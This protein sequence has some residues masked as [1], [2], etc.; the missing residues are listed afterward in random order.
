MKF[1]GKC[2]TPLKRP[3]GAAQPAPS[4]ADLQRSATEALEQQTAA[5]EIPRVISSS[6]QPV[7]DTI[8]RNATQLCRAATASVSL[9]DGR[10]VY[11]PANYGSLPDAMAEIRAGFPRSL[12]RETVTGRG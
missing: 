12:D 2:G 8:V 5:S 1:C 4:Y 9:S 7:F 11:L 6:L 10:M 3:K